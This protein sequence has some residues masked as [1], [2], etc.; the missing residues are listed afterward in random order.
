MFLSSPLSALLVTLHCA[1]CR[2]DSLCRGVASNETEE[3]IASSLFCARTR[4]HALAI[5]YKTSACKRKV[6]YITVTDLTINRDLMV[7]KRPAALIMTFFT[8]RGRK[9]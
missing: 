1:L 2:K 3:A 8:K 4:V 9:G 7:G 6:N 5:S